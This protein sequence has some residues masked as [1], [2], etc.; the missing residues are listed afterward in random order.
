MENLETKKENKFERLYIIGYG[1]GGGF[2]GAQNF[3][4]IQSDNLEQ[5]EKE[6]YE[7]ACN[8]YEM[9]EGMHGLRNISQI[10]EEDDIEDEDE[11]LEIYNEE[12]E[13]WLDYSARVYSKEYEQTLIGYHYD[14]P[15]KEITGDSKL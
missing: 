6:S 15:F 14:N 9:Y 5:A 4:V 1:L 8:E 12:R 3:Q 10:M 11:A 7:M 2:G 13:S